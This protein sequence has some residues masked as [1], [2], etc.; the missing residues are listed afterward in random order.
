[1]T[2]ELLI[3]ILQT[4]T[5]PLRIH[6][7]TEEDTDAADFTVVKGRI[8]RKKTTKDSDDETTTK[9]I[10]TH[11]YE[12][13]MDIITKMVEL[14]GLPATAF[15]GEEFTH[16]ALLGLCYLLRDMG[17]GKYLAFLMTVKLQNTYPNG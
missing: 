16:R 9:K 7:K 13:N 6:N 8:K 15:D 11:K 12:I 4:T 10:A 3:H 2:D 1:M 17:T 5:D 14:G